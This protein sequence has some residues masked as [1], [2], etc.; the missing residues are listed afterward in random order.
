MLLQK[1]QTLSQ[2]ITHTDETIE[3]PS[4]SRTAQSMTS[5]DLADISSISTTPSIPSRHSRLSARLSKTGSKSSSS[6]SLPKVSPTQVSPPGGMK[7]SSSDAVVR[8]SSSSLASVAFS[9]LMS[10]TVN[11]PLQRRKS[12]KHQTNTNVTMETNSVPTEQKSSDLTKPR[13]PALHTDRHVA[14]E[15]TNDRPQHPSDTMI[16]TSQWL[17]KESFGLEPG[18][19]FGARTVVIGQN[20]DQPPP[21]MYPRRSSSSLAPSDVLFPD[22]DDGGQKRLS[23]DSHFSRSTSSSSSLRQAAGSFSAE[24][25]RTVTDGRRS[26]ADDHLFSRPGQPLPRRSS[27]VIT[28][29]QSKHPHVESSEV[30]KDPET[31]AGVRD[32]KTLGEKETVDEK[33]DRW[34]MLYLLKL[35]KNVPKHKKIILSIFYIIFQSSAQAAAITVELHSV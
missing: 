23:K 2:N 6:S 24:T 11:L 13:E 14:M 35:G 28:T 16:F 4:P 15:T 34:E 3:S 7:M 8:R 29:G 27:H 18:R 20:F 31:S 1:L 25:D 17:A 30:E 33:S 32:G 21:P 10:S 9:D 5:G 22:D 26:E 12:T 19:H